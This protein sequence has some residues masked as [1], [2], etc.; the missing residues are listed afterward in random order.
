[1]C[2][3]AG[4]TR[5]LGPLRS[6]AKSPGVSPTRGRGRRDVGRAAHQTRDELAFA[7]DGEAVG[8]RLLRVGRC[9]VELTAAGRGSATSDLARYLRDELEHAGLPTGQ[10]PH[11]LAAML[12]GMAVE[13]IR[14][15]TTMSLD[16]EAVVDLLT[17]F[18]I[19]GVAGLAPTTLERADQAPVSRVAQPRSRTVR[20]R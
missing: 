8:A 18:T 12:V 10:L 16:P 15:G 9:R 1:M 6:E 4:A 7:D 3:R 13:T 14:L 11:I 19:A 2:R 17:E 5:G 20:N